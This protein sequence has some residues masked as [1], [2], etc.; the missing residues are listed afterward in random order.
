MWM[1]SSNLRPGYSQRW[2]EAVQAYRTLLR[3][4]PT[5]SRAADARYWLASSLEQ[6]QRW[7]EA[8]EAYDATTP[9]PFSDTSFTLTRAAG[10]EDLRS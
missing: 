2:F 8:A 1:G 7:D 6:D 4:F 5:S 10:L 3:E 9:T